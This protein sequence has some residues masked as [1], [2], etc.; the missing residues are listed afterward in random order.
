ML[1]RSALLLSGLSILAALVATLSS[2]ATSPDLLYFWGPKAQAFAAARTI[3]ASFLRDSTL[4]YMHPSYPPL[5]TNLLA[6]A[7]QVAGRFPW[8][9][10]TLTL[11]LL[12]A[13]LAL[14]LP[15]V[16]RLAAPRRL[17]WASSALILAA[18]GYFGHG[19]G[20]AGNADRY[21]QYGRFLEIHRDRLPLV[22][23]GIGRALWSCHRAE[24]VV[25]ASL[26]GLGHLSHQ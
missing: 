12:L 3:D 16:L 24:L 22:L 11:P 18:L 14:A 26:V 9:A 10:A 20:I 17:A 15:G 1:E 6:F 5:V 2:A 19:L 23:S 8:L 13:A 25:G 21:E 4:L 7:S